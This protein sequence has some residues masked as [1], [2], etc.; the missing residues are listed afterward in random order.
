[1]FLLIFLPFFRDLSFFPGIEVAPFQ[2]KFSFKVI[3][4]YLA[5][6]LPLI[7]KKIR[8]AKR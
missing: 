6:F 5:L 3:L 2:I 7:R 8:L 4:N 1:M